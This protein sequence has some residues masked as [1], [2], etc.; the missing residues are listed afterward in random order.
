MGI[1]LLDSERKKPVKKNVDEWMTE[2]DVSEGLCASDLQTFP[3]VWPCFMVLLL[4]LHTVAVQILFSRV[5]LT[6]STPTAGLRL[7]Q[8]ACNTQTHPLKPPRVHRPPP[9]RHPPD[10]T[11][12]SVQIKHFPSSFSSSRLCNTFLHGHSSS[13]CHWRGRRQTFSTFWA[14]RW[15]KSSVVLFPQNNHYIVK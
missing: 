7:G 5:L 11:S 14:L 10:S 15:I 6:S 1:D 4:P 2:G 8:L 9:P 12:D 13:P 3:S